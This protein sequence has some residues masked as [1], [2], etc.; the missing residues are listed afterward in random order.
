MGKV[1]AKV[2][3]IQVMPPGMTEDRPEWFVAALTVGVLSGVANCYI[4]GVAA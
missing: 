1:R 4:V 2:R 3:A